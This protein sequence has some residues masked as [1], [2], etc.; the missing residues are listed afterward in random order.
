MHNK[1]VTDRQTDRQT[2]ARLQRS[3]TRA[4][5][6]CYCE[7]DDSDLRRVNCNLRHCSTRHYSVFEEWNLQCRS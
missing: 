3:F 5:M 1:K 2:D 4:A 7:T 6:P